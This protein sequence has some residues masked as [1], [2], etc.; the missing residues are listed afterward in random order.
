MHRQSMRKTLSGS[1][2][3]SGRGQKSAKERGTSSSP[4]PPSPPPSSSSRRTGDGWLH[5]NGLVLVLCIFAAGCAV[6]WTA[7]GFLDS[8][9]QTQPLPPPP[10]HGNGTREDNTT[11]PAPLPPLPPC[12]FYPGGFRE[13]A[14]VGECV[15]PVQMLVT[16]V[17]K[18]AAM[19]QDEATAFV[20]SKLIGDESAPVSSRVLEGTPFF[21]AGVSTFS[22]VDE[23]PGKVKNATAIALYF[24]KLKHEHAKDEIPPQFHDTSLA[25]QQQHGVT[26][27]PVC[28]AVDGAPDAPERVPV[29]QNCP[30][31]LLVS[32]EVEDGQFVYPMNTGWAGLPREL[33]SLSKDIATRLKDTPKQQSQQQQHQQQHQQ[34]QQQQQPTKTT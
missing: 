26:T 9:G 25:L 27:I 20:G 31:W 6:G 14:D 21:V 33:R 8:Q 32:Q 18:H 5:G 2:H 22:N 11:D 3:S 12:D 10:P 29:R 16:G 34:Q 4:L 19:W 13:P 30:H 24:A 15:Y 17:P 7:R 1:S 23:V 28:L